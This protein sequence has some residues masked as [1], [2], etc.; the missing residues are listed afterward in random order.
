[1]LID[2]EGS[3]T[4]AG[5]GEDGIA[6]SRSKGGNSRLADTGR[7]FLTLDEMDA[8][9]AGCIVHAS[10]R[11]VVKVTLGDAS[12]PGRNLPEEG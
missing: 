11:I 8:Y 1:M 5:G 3:D 9:V 2:G 7:Q 4:L 6:K 12:V 10:D